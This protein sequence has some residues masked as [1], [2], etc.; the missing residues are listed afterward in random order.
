MSRS[1]AEFV[2]SHDFYESTVC[3]LND[4]A[5]FPGATENMMEKFNI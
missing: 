4:R 1:T 2:S 5:P 3:L